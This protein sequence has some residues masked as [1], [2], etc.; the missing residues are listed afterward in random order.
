MVK[1]DW[2][3]IGLTDTELVKRIEE[4]P[5]DVECEELVLYGN[6]LQNVPNLTKYKQLLG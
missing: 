2:S 4:L 5:E 1:I 3:R 6:E